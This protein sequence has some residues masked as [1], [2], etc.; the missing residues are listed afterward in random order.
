[1]MMRTVAQLY[2]P[3]DW[4]SMDSVPACVA[5]QRVLSQHPSEL[6][7]FRPPNLHGLSTCRPRKRTGHLRIVVVMCETL[8]PQVSARQKTSGIGRVEEP[9]CLSGRPVRICRCSSQ[10]GR[11]ERPGG[12]AEADEKLPAP[13]GRQFQGA[14]TWLPCCALQVHLQICPASR[15][16]RL[17]FLRT[18]GHAV[19]RNCVSNWRA[20]GRHAQAAQFVC[21]PVCVSLDVLDDWQGASGLHL[22]HG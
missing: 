17:R 5:T 16:A 10:A 2:V 14:D 15:L 20:G 21:C 19:V 18:S 8:C 1:M 7:C 11:P 6:Q 13:D 3:A 12:Q 22:R 9:W 4:K